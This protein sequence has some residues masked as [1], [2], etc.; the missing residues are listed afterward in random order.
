MLQTLNIFPNPLTE[1]ATIQFSL[2][3]SDEVSLQVLNISGSE[4]ASLFAGPVESGQVYQINFD[5]K[6]LPAGI[7]ISELITQSGTFLYKKILITR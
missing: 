5:A 1:H 6:D 4:V 7:Y 2:P 3:N